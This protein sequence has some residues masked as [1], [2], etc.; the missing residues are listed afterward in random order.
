MW[1]LCTY[2]PVFFNLGPSL[3]PKGDTTIRISFL[4]IHTR[5]CRPNAASIARQFLGSPTLPWGRDKETAT[6]QGRLP[7]HL[8]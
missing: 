1:L 5:W 2:E 3:G 6:R 8:N 4:R 7:D